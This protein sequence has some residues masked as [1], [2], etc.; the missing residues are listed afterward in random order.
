MTAA[1]ASAQPQPS[2]PK[3]LSLG[4]IFLTLYIDLIGFSISFPLI[5]RLLTY[6]LDKEGHAGVLG[7]L[8]GRVESLAPPSAH[9]PLLVAA[10]VGGVLGSAYSLL[11]FLFAPVWG[12][13]S[14]RAG[15]RPVLL[16]T[17]AGNAFSYLLWAFSGSFWLFIVSRLIGGAM[18]GNL[19]VAT[20]AVADVT[21]R[22]NRAKGMGLIGVA[23]GLGFITG[24]AIGGI[25]GAV[26]P[27]P[28]WARLGLNPFSAVALVAMAFSLLNLVWIS[29]RF[30]ET[31][32]PEHRSEPGAERTLHPFRVLLS[33]RDASVRRANLV[34][35]L[36]M[37]VFA[38][39]EMTVSFL[40]TQRLLYT[41]HQ[42]TYIFVFAGVMSILTQGVLVRRLMPRF[43]EK[44]G[45]VGGMA[46]IAAGLAGLALAG[47]TLPVYAS[48]GL[49]SIGSGFANVAFSALISLYS[50]RDQQGR[51]LGVFRSLGSLARAVGPLAAGVVFWWCDS[52]FT[53]ML[54]ALL[55]LIPIVI[56]LRLP[57][58]VQ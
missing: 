58:P 1:T 52:L 49:V 48:L 40:V 24:P 10:L 30:R 19:S 18:S 20:A 5:P 54:G 2:P 35:F 29:L 9:N 8:L 14:D 33:I 50:P 4:V 39:Y 43:G 16:M 46:A 17:V 27:G 28:R 22:E 21:T 23:F 26:E 6:Y 11:Q 51:V 45:A 44:S 34:F 3:P 56:G 36:L 37:L 31:L 12:A 38:G 13:H 25:I 41:E 47:R 15:R 32:L 53:Y 55:L 7:W 42:L 57:K